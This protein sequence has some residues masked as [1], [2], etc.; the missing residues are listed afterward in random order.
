LSIVDY[1]E[2]GAKGSE[3]RNPDKRP[4][5]I[6]TSE[7]GTYSFT[8]KKQPLAGAIICREKGLYSPAR[9][10]HSLAP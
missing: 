1:R 4:H 8:S 10:G 7:R 9:M 3:Q 6:G 5:L 2:I